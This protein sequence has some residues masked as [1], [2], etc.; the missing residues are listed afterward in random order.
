MAKISAR[1]C[2]EVARIRYAQ[3]GYRGIMVLRSDGAV[4]QRLTGDVGNAYTIL[5][6]VKDWHEKVGNTTAG[7]EALLG[8]VAAKRGRTMI[9]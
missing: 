2:R 4:L 1:G 6:K 3:G 8:R 9:S 5:G 7:A